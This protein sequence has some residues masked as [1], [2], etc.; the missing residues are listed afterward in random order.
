M[1]NA[2]VVNACEARS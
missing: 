1:N 2:G